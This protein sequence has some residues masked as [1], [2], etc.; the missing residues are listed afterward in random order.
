MFA[1]TLVMKSLFLALRP[2]QWIKNAF[3]FIPLIFGKELFLFPVNLKVVIA[4]SL[5]CMMAS[6]VYLCN[7]ILDYKEDKLHPQKK[8][9]PIVSGKVST[10]QAQITV[11]VLA[12]LA[13]IFSLVL[14]KSFGWVIVGYFVLNIFYSLV[15]KKIV[16]IDV[17]CIGVFFLLRII[18]GMA[19]IKVE[20]S[21]WMIFMIILLALFLGFNKRRQELNQKDVSHREVLTKYDHYFIDQ[22]IAVITSSIVVTYM[23]YTVDQRTINL[24]HT[25]HLAYT[26][27]F[28]YYGIFRYLYL[29]HKESRG[30]DPTYVLYSDFSMQ[31]NLLLWVVSCVMVIYFHI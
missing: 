29:V 23:L 7:D 5:F 27:P 12:L 21:Y 30:E 19:I 6:A 9:R 15:L 10:K 28:V 25:N 17:F 8:L 3:I 16:I 11:T 20:Y 14:D 4:F 2:K 1:K 13:T 24:F 31:L 18:A 22:M 26:I